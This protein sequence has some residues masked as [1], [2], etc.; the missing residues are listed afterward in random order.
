MKPKN[1]YQTLTEKLFKLYD[2]IEEGKVD[3]DKAKTMVQS[4]STINSI[5]RAKLIATRVTSEE[6]R[7]KF[8][9]D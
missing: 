7:V 2:D 4:A 6:K 5:Q 3:I 9:E 8:Y 1:N